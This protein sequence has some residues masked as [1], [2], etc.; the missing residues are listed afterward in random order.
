MRVRERESERG[1]PLFTL[2]VSSAGFVALSHLL[3]VSQT[4]FQHR[5]SHVGLTWDVGAHCARS[6]TVGAELP[7]GQPCGP[8]SR[9]RR[10]RTSTS[11]SWSRPP[12]YQCRRSMRKSWKVCRPY[13]VS[14]LKSASGASS[15]RRSIARWS[16][17]LHQSSVPST[18]WRRLTTSPCRGS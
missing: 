2:C 14:F 5:W 9:W 3:F 16:R 17:S 8:S 15:R 10:T 12:V 7:D 11:A 1:V 6:G 4:R 18:S 13:H